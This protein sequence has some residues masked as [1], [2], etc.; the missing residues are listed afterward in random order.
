MLNLFVTAD[1]AAARINDGEIL[2][3]AG[4]EHILKTLPRGHW[5]GGTTAYFMAQEGGKVSSDQ[6]FCT[7]L[8][9][10]MECRVSV[11]GVGALDKLTANRFREGFGVILIPAFTAIHENYAVNAPRLSGLYDQTLMGWVTGVHLD[12]LATSKPCVFDGETGT[13]YTTDGVVMHV[14]LPPSVAA[15]IDIINL[16]TQGD[17]PAISFP[18]DGFSV[19]DCMID[20]ATKNFAS[21]CQAHKVDTKLPLVADYAGAMVNVAIRA[22]EDGRVSFFAPVVAGQTYRFASPVAEQSSSYDTLGNDLSRA[23]NA[24]SCN[25]VLNFVYAGLE[26]K[27]TAGFIGPVTFGEIAFIVLNQTL[28]RLDVMKL[29]TATGMADTNAVLA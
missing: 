20:G 24:M 28:V 15:D 17:G 23:A 26:G 27:P 2:V 4:A 13:S 16:F 3:L 9:D 8:D 25:C 22:I 29:P 19:G 1:Q 11:F 18:E 6:L 7:V 21:W 5:I 12:D 14:A 10:A